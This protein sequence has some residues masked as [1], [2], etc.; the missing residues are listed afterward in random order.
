MVPERWQS[1]DLGVSI[2]DKHLF[3]DDPDIHFWLSLFLP[4]GMVCYFQKNHQS[5]NSNTANYLFRTGYYEHYRIW[6]IRMELLI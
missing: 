4:W 1:V 5:K 6:D 3:W 2:L